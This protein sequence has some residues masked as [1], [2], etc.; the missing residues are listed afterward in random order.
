M[1]VGALLILGLGCG[2]NVAPVV[3]GD[4]ASTSDG[5]GTTVDGARDS[6]TV[7]A[8]NDI[9][10]IDS[11]SDGAPDVDDR[12]CVISASNYD[13]SCTVDSDCVEVTSGDYCN[14]ALCRCGG[15]VINVG[16]Q[17][18]FR[19]DVLKTPIGSG[20]LMGATCGCAVPAGPCC[21]QGMCKAG[22]G[23]DCSSPA[24]TLAA[25]VDAG[26]TCRPSAL[27]GVCPESPPGACA[28]ADESCCVN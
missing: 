11:S 5:R 18:Q 10:S 21:R 3:G 9:P 27:Y 20:A 2:G 26:G 24:D 19:A 22:F 8:S 4:A 15:S 12:T 25:C 1:R 14:A 23:Q 7:E 28:Y 17:A 16:A 6:A 13:Q